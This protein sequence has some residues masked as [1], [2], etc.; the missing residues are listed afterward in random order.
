V[1]TKRGVSVEARTYNCAELCNY[2]GETVEVRYLP[3]HQRAVEM[4]R[5][6]AYLGTAFRVD[7]LDPAEMERLLRRRAEEARWLAERQ[8]VAWWS[9][10]PFKAGGR[11]PGLVSSLTAQPA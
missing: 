4:F 6:G 9:K 11:Q 8:R 7:D 2:V 5:H 1:V 10:E 3:R